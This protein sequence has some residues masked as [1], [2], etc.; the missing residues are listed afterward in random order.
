[1]GA[2]AL[3]T[4]AAIDDKESRN[5]NNNRPV[6][7]DGN[8]LAE[9]CNND[10]NISRQQVEVT[11]PPATIRFKRRR[12]ATLRRQEEHDSHL[13]L[14][15]GT[16]DSPFKDIIKKLEKFGRKGRELREEGRE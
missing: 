10:G 5:D 12:S 15:L 7:H 14:R 9:K 8:G 4:F 16:E 2:C 1:M 6:V 3:E 13:S 11:R